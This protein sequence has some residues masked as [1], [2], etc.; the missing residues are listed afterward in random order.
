MGKHLSALY[1]YITWQT[2]L[3]FCIQMNPCFSFSCC[4]WSH[5]WWLSS[6][7]TAGYLVAFLFSLLLKCVIV[8]FT[9]WNSFW[10]LALW[11]FFLGFM[12]FFFFKQENDEWWMRNG[13]WKPVDTWIHTCNIQSLKFMW[14]N[15]ACIHYIL[16]AVDKG[17]CTQL[18]CAAI[19]RSSDYLSIQLCI[20][21]S[22]QMRVQ[23]LLYDD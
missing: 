20:I 22:T 19:W 15:S 6:L 17:G 1:K 18:K 16:W 8:I 23:M 14:K 5:S 10:P 9:L 11:L 12:T 3:F 4:F 2:L 7:Q 13:F 21:C